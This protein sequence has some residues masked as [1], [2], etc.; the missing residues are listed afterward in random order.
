MDTTQTQHTMTWQIS[1]MHCSSCS[2]LIDEA[3]E[4]LDGVISSSTSLKKKLT[5]VAFDR[6]RCNADQIAA[7]IVGAGYQ[8]VPP[9]DDAHTTRRS[10]FRRTTP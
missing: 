5:T 3:V 8:P 6:T 10:W 9:T 4:E 2:I 7:V 1:G